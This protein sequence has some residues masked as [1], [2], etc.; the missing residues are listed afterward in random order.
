M[1]ARMIRMGQQDGHGP[2]Y[3]IDLI[4]LISNVS[5]SL[6][7]LHAMTCTLTHQFK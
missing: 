6:Y 7:A 4:H 5:L 1:S 2:V 3:F